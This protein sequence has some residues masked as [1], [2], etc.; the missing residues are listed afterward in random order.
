M[1]W[2]ESLFMGQSIAHSLMLVALVI[3]TGLLLNK[4]KIA[5]ISLGVTWILFMGILFS[6]FGMVLHPMVLS[7]VKDLGLI[8]FVYSVG[9]QVGPGFFASFKKGGVSMNLLAVSNV[10]MAGIVAYVLVLLTDTFAPTMV[11]V[12]SGAVTNTPG[13]G[14]AIQTYSDVTGTEEASIGMAYAIAYP[15]GVLGVIITIILIKVF[16][17]V[18]L[19]KEKEEIAKKSGK[20]DGAT[21]MAIEAHNEAI[22]GKNIMEIDRL[23]ERNFVISRLCHANGK[24][25]IPTSKSI[26]NEGDRLLIVTSLTNAPHIAAFLG[27]KIEMTQDEWEKLDTQLVSR[28][29][30]VTNSEVNGRKLGVLNIRA[31]YGINIARVN[32]AGLDL[33]ASRDLALQLGDTLT[34]VGAENAI[35]KVSKLVGNTAH[36]LNE[37]NL[38]PI[39]LGI[40]LGVVLGSLPIFIPGIP[41][42]VKL[43][44]AGGPLVVAILVAYFGPKY[45][46]VTYATHSANM[47]LREVGISLFLAAVGLG[48]GQGFVETVINGGYMWILY[49]FIITLVPIWITA[50]IGRFVLKLDY[51]SI[52]GLI[53]GAQTNPIALAYSTNSFGVAQSSVAFATVYPIT[54]FMRV[55]TAQMLILFLI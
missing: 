7:F 9:M 11:G 22:F 46:M 1:S 21:I 40:F 10:L 19:D 12:M 54:M 43:G 36:R 51:F 35:E 8:L 17:R 41:Q 50:I 52:I 20:K 23:M 2:I 4:I 26:V 15:L 45:K 33:V 55:L 5:G 42:A 27:K 28:Q 13:L 37:P 25:E 31:Q 18:N 32:R 48:S 34:V 38:F 53:S 44:L 29:L 6:H 30:I 16:F 24:M 14:A 39:F 3:A 47:M 49:G